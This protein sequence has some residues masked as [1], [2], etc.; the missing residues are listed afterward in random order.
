MQQP[1]QLFDVLQCN[2]RLPPN[3]AFQ[4]TALRRARSG[5]FLHFGSSTG[6]TLG[7]VGEGRKAAA[8]RWPLGAPCR[9]PIM[10]LDIPYN[11]WEPLS[12]AEVVQLF[13]NA[14][15][16]WGLA[17]GYAVEQFLGTAIREHSDSDV[18]VYRDEQLELQHWLAGW[19]LY[20]ADPPGI[21]R[22]WRA[23]EFLPSGIHDIWGHRRDTQAWQ[24]Q[25]MLT[26]VEGDEWFSRRS[27][28]IRGQRND[29]IVVYQGIACVRVEVQ[30]LYKAR[31]ARPKDEQDFQ[32]CLPLLSVEAKQWLKDQLRL[33]YPEG[34]QWL[35]FLA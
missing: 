15:F 29:L 26:E 31:N 30:L 9:E 23:D 4:P 7:G 17:G 12:V 8:E 6:P 32:A 34:H 2:P 11:R 3:T 18:V 33:L 24:L 21:L 27:H 19:H 14:P 20:A 1:H 10:K 5:L 28:L 25:I 35:A 16:T 13:A 22:S